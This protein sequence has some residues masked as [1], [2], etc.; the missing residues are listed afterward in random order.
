MVTYPLLFWLP[1]FFQAIFLA[2]PLRSAVLILPLCCSLIG[3][4]LL[5]GILLGRIKRS[6]LH[7]RFA[8]VPITV[9]LGLNSLWDGSTSIAEMAGFQI[10]AGGGIGILF[11]A[12]PL[13]MQASVENA[14]DQGLSV[15]ILVCFRLFGGLIGLAMGSTAFSSVFSR[16]IASV[17]TL[18]TNVVVQ[19]DPSPALGFIPDLRGLNLAP[20]ARDEV[21][22]V[23]L[24]AMRVVWYVL[25]GFSCLG[26]I[27]SLF[28]QELPLN[29][30]DVGQ[31]H[32]EK[33]V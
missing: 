1:L 2:T 6:R 9:G 30:E 33:W 16:S 7:L 25:A 23:Y 14:D 17:G 10:M 24:D 32:L 15:G 12:S 21:Q 27:T 22:K 26:F 31:Q 4:S 13:I 18:P 8:W 3:F 29:K 19:Q 11:T 20:Q 5:S 28:V